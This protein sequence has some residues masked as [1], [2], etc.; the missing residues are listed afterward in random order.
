MIKAKDMVQNKYYLVQQPGPKDQCLVYCY[1][2]PDFE[3]GKV[4]GIGFNVADGAGWMPL[5]DL[6]KNTEI[7]EA[8]IV[9][10]WEVSRANMR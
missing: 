2:N 10:E 6:T 7:F 5:R 1:V 4:L 8:K 9:I 3:D